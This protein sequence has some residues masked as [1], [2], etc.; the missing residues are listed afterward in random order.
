MFEGVGGGG[1]G[2]PTALG[3]IDVGASYTRGAWSRWRCGWWGR[4]GRWGG[5][6]LELRHGWLKRQSGDI[7]CLVVFNT[8]ADFGCRWG[9]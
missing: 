3:H 7:N 1:G 9:V 8:L 4:R 2:F 6:E 5:I